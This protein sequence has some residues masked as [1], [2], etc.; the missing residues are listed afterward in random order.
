MIIM[1][2]DG[3]DDNG[4]VVDDGDEESEPESEVLAEKF[5]PSAVRDNISW[6]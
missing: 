5:S 4:D 6:R 2:D 1:V 3:D